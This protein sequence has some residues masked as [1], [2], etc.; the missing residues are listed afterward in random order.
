MADE[1]LPEQFRYFD[2]AR[3]HIDGQPVVITRTGFTSEL[4][5][6]FY[7]EP[8]VDAVAIGECIMEAGRA[9]KMDT[10]PAEVTNARRIEG[11]LLF[12]GTDFD[13]SVTPF[14]A[15]FASLVDEDKGDFIGRAALQEADRRCRTWGL[16]CAE[17]TPRHGRTLLRDSTEIGLVT[18][19][20]WS[21]TL[22]CGIAIVRL[23]DPNLGPGTDVEVMCADGSSRFATVTELPLYD[24]AGDIP[25]GRATDTPEIPAVIA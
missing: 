16:V 14:E 17:G 15:G 6:E 5:W 18:S 7:L 1:G 2:M 20:A 11:G 12:A 13:E 3:I 9:Y 24:K 4:G 22:Q 23:D 19:S 25:R 10:T 8:H 21:P